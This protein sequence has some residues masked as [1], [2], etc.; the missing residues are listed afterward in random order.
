VN[1][2]GLVQ[3]IGIK[4]GRAMTRVVLIRVVLVVFGLAVCAPTV[5]LGTM[6]PPPTSQEARQMAVTL[7][8]QGRWAEALN[9]AKIALERANLVFGADSLQTAKSHILVGDLYARRGKSVSAE[10]HYTRGINII[11]RTSGGNAPGLVR[12]LVA[13]A[14]VH[15]QKG[16]LDKAEYFYKKALMVNQGVGRP[17]CPTSAPALL[18]LASLCQREGRT[19]L[20]RDCLGKALAIYGAYRKYDPSL[21]KMAISALCNL[22]E[23]DSRD[24]KYAQA[25]SCYRRAAEILENGMSA[26]LALLESIF[27]RLG[28]CCKNSGSATQ[29][30]TAYQRADALKV[31]IALTPLLVKTN[32]VITR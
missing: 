31:Q 10:M 20:A 32:T 28:D 1:D 15:Q 17:E 19:T 4:G 30:R 18:G 21:D 9:M 23:I 2:Y 12:P 13:L 24:S 14:A 6:I 16:A 29:A 5:A 27:V 22:G 26:D 7:Y 11:R 8:E 3:I 25:A